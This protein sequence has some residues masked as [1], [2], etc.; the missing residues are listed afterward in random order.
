MVLSHRRDEREDR[1][2]RGERE[3]MWGPP[4]LIMFYVKL[5]CGS[6]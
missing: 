2:K 1:D 5:I 6:H 3:D 4:F